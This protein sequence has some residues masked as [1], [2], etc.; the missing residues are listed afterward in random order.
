MTD[1]ILGIVLQDTVNQVFFP[2]VGFLDD[3]SAN[4]L[5]LMTASS[6]RRIY[7]FKI[8]TKI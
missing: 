8:I 1:I 4:S 7:T 3:S 5:P 6:S 2:V